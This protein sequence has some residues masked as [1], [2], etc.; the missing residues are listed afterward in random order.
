MK[1][2]RSR[3]ILSIMDFAQSLAA[4]GG[5][6]LFAFA[7]N[8]ALARLLGA[9]AFGTYITLLSAALAVG[10]LAAYGTGPLLTKEISAQPVAERSLIVKQLG[11]WSIKRTGLLS[12]IGMAAVTC[13]LLTGIAAPKSDWYE[14]VATLVML[15]VSMIL[16]LAVSVLS[17]LS[18]VALGQTSSNTIK[19]ALLLLGAGLLI[20]IGVRSAAA[21]LW[22]QV[23]ATTFS[24][25][26]AG[27]WVYKNMPVA[28]VRDILMPHN[29]AMTKLAWQRSAK[30]FFA[31]SAS[32]LVLSRLDVVVVGA[33]TDQAQVGL[34]GAA[35]RIAQFAGLTGILLIA[36]LQPRISNHFALCRHDGLIE[37]MKIGLAGSVGMTT[38]MVAA[39]WF[40]APWLIS[41]M[42]TSFV[43]AI[44]PLRCLLCS[45]LAWS[46]CVPYY[47]F[48]SMT[49]HE[50]RL[51]KLLWIQSIATLALTAPLSH[52]FGALGAAI[53]WFT[54]TAL[55]TL[56]MVRMG[57][58]ALAAHG[59]E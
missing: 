26:I 33:F 29:D 7:A 42:G 46:F 52:Y 59:S 1:I 54:G 56:W 12:V 57:V 39:G 5:G 38:I 31:V 40:S 53:A 28:A 21:A 51:A 15:P 22:L 41:L 19:N 45:Y 18:K 4:R 10:G 49:G 50:K 23:F 43:P 36:W 25:C 6:A 24:V 47:A 27:F 16:T 17:G 14:I 2:R 58:A 55:A 20:L 30:H 35:A 34:F 37:N 11:L 9:K 3:F 32:L 8:I 13:W 44:W 48:L